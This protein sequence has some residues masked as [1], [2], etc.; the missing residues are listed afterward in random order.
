MDATGGVGA[1]A[2]CVSAILGSSV[3]VSGRGAGVCGAASWSAGETGAAF[4]FSETARLSLVPGDGC[5]FT[6]SAVGGGD[7]LVGSA[8]VAGAGVEGC[9]EAA[10][11]VGGGTLR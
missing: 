5:D 2:A 11:G 1:G 9:T 10:S 6:F 3:G 7:A 8:V 4:G